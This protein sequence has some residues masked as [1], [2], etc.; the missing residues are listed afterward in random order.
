MEKRSTSSLVYE[1]LLKAGVVFFLFSV[2]YNVFFLTSK[3]QNNFW[4]TTLKVIIVVIFFALSL[5]TSALRRKNFRSFAFFVVFIT[6]F[7]KIITFIANEGFDIEI[8]PVYILLIIMSLY[9][10]YKASEH[11]SSSHRR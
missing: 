3:V 8:I 1:I 10:I 7:F 2:F 5:I 9:L 6:S 11:S 4:E